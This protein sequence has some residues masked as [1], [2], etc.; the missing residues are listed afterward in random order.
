MWARLYAEERTEDIESVTLGDFDFPRSK[1]GALY[2]RAERLCESQTE[3][4]HWCCGKTVRTELGESGMFSE[5]RDANVR[6]LF[7]SDS[8]EAIHFRRHAKACNS[9]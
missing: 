3:V 1:C 5:I 2:W 6:D 7:M 4:P 9:I 8:E